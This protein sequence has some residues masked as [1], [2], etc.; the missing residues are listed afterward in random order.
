MNDH[1][2]D[3]FGSWSTTAAA[4]SLSVKLLRLLVDRGALL[5]RD[6]AL[7]AKLLPGLLAR[8][9][10]SLNVLVCFLSCCARLL[11]HK[12][13][14][15]ALHEVRLRQS[16]SCLRLASKPHTGLRTLASGDLAD[17]LLLHRF[18]RPH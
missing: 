6:E 4:S 18:H 1:E 13:P 8:N 12:L 5:D 10:P 9:S 14:G 15:L 2:C 7:D 16:A 11:A 17:C 3:G